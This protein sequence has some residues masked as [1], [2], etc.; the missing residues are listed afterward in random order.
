[1]RFQEVSDRRKDREAGIEK[2]IRA[3]DDAESRTR[4]NPG[5]LTSRMWDRVRGMLRKARWRIMGQEL[6]GS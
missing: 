3:I 2:E 4:E 6:K 5:D 1:M